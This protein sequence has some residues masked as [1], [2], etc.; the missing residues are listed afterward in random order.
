[1]STS[2]PKCWYD[3]KAGWRSCKRLSREWN[4][5]GWIWM[6]GQRDEFIV[7]EVTWELC[8]DVYPPSQAGRSSKQAKGSSWKWEVPGSIPGCVAVVIFPL[9]SRRSIAS[10]NYNLCIYTYI[11]LKDRPVATD[12]NRRDFLQ[13]KARSREGQ[14][15]KGK[16]RWV[17]Y[18]K[19]KGVLPL[20]SD[21]KGLV[22]PSS[23]AR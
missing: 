14:S 22:A 7:F 5:G 9:S 23:S 2:K 21:T 8:I 15:T 11:F 13:L 19:T 10:F 12:A 17:R 6:E 3:K 16:E 18:N 1:M 20:W 4:L